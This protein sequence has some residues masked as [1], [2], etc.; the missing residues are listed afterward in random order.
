MKADAE[1]ENLIKME[2]K[3]KIMLN[4]M[5]GQK[6][7]AGRVSTGSDYRNFVLNLELSEE[8]FQIIPI[9]TNLTNS[10]PNLTNSN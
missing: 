3:Q 8:T 5:R 2:H 1:K 6:A 10:V 7:V 4:D 9:L